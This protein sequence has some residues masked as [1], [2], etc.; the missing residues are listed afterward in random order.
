M[1]MEMEKRERKAW[2]IG[3]QVLVYRRT[4]RDRP[5]VRDFEQRFLLAPVFVGFGLG[6]MKE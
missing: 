6:L 1:E 5:E 2:R 3:P 4:E